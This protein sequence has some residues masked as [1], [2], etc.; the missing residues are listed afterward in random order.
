LVA[1]LWRLAAAHGPM[2]VT[3]SQVAHE[4]GIGRATL[5]KNF[6]DVETILHARHEQHILDHLTRLRELRNQSDDPGDRLA[7]VTHVYA[8]ICH[9][10]AQHGS[11]E[12]SALTHQPQR[13]DGAEQELLTLFRGVIADAK[14]AGAMHADASNEEL[15]LYCVHALGAAGS[16]P[17]QDAA[18]RLADLTLRALSA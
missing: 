17:T 9:H 4:A 2:S 10:R 5:H 16:L 11:I 18:R 14:A 3:M 15:A 1:G 13:V 6:P 8:Q 12:L 7:A